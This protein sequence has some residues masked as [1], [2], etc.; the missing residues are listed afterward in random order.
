MLG[1]DWAA[2]AWPSR[3]QLL[4]GVAHHRDSGLQ[5]EEG[6]GQEGRDGDRSRQ[7]GKAAPPGTSQ[8]PRDLLD[9]FTH[10]LPSGCQWTHQVT[11]GGLGR[12]QTG[13]AR[14]QTQ[15]HIPAPH[16]PCDLPL[17]RTRVPTCTAV[18]S[19]TGSR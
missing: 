5:V 18:V 4:L 15:V 10:I 12:G 8:L 1:P 9:S 2:R 17:C 3:L 11:L 19:V 14:S 6:T 7:P 16:P 13:A